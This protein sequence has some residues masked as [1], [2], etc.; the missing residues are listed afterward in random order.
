MRDWD[1]RIVVFRVAGLLESDNISVLML[2]VSWVPNDAVVT[3]RDSLCGFL[4]KASS[5]SF[6]GHSAAVED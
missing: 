1:E 6:V 3:C 4:D 2:T 5:V